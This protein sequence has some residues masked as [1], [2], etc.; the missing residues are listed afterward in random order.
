MWSTE[1][2]TY[3]DQTLVNDDGIGIIE[4]M[5]NRMYENRSDFVVMTRL[6]PLW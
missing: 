2:T 3:W 5:K 4:F 6:A 1:I